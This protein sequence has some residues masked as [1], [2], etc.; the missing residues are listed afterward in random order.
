MDQGDSLPAE[1]LERRWLRHR[2]PDNEVPAAVAFDALLVEADDLVVFLSGLRVYTTG[3]ELSIE[4][5]ARP[6][7]SEDEDDHLGRLLH[8]RRGAADGLLLG[9]E[10][11]DG[12][13]CSNLGTLAAQVP[14]ERTPTLHSGGGGGSSRSAE[15]SYFLSPLPPP[16]ELRLVSA[17]PGRGIP[18][19]TLSLPTEAILDAATRARVLWPWAPERRQKP[20]RR[21]PEL[22]AGGWFAEH[23]GS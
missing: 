1:E 5:R 6:S 8:G 2:P 21:A 15:A 11:A 23:L 14:D 3:V 19:S 7:A 16:G 12:R 9:I 17:L 22:P 20:G 18:E 4:L 10:F 13:T